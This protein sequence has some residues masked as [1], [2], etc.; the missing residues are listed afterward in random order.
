M[1][2]GFKFDERE[3]LKAIEPELKKVVK[4][5]QKAIDA[6]GVQYKGRPVDEI[7]PVL[8]REFARFDMSVDSDA[9]LTEYAQAISDGEAVKVRIGQK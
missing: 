2:S 3:L 6:L 1:G 5:L 8:K 4:Q 7:K 9:E